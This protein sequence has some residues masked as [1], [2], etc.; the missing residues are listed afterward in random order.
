M[1]VSFALGEFCVGK[2]F[3]FYPTILTDAF[4][5]TRF[6]R[7]VLPDASQWNIGGIGPSGVGAGVEHVYFIFF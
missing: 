7:R 3:A 2:F 4:Y 6:I 1:L 5:P